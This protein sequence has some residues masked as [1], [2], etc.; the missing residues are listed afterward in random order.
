MG[1]PLIF[2]YVMLLV[3]SLFMQSNPENKSQANGRIEVK[4]DSGVTD[5]KLKETSLLEKHDH[6]LTLSLEVLFNLESP[7]TESYVATF[8][9][10][11]KSAVLFGDMGIHCL[12]DGKPLRLRKTGNYP[13]KITPEEREQVRACIGQMLALTVGSLTDNEYGAPLTN[14][15]LENI[16]A[17]MPAAF[18]LI[19]K[20]AH[21][22]VASSST[23]DFLRSLPDSL[24]DPLL[25]KCQEF[26]EWAEPLETDTW[27][28]EIL[29]LTMRLY[30][31]ETGAHDC[32]MSDEEMGR[33]AYRLSRLVLIE[34]RR[35]GGHY[36]WVDKYTIL[37]RRNGPRYIKALGSWTE[38]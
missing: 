30:L 25:L 33:M 34:W 20:K 18:H 27:D 9:S 32:R 31:D 38:H 11:S 6:K 2:A 19:T 7:G 26:F 36:S 17:G 15:E 22:L 23:D 10:Y 16:A 3:S 13:M 37:N 24:L 35:R 4:T 8:Y 29:A 21:G 14:A 1:N 28:T 12:I 5:I